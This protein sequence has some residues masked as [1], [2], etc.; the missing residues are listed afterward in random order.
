MFKF[1]LKNVAAISLPPATK[2][3]LLLNMVTPEDL[4]SDED[5]EGKLTFSVSIY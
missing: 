4:V 3:L 1:T 2:I 5:Y